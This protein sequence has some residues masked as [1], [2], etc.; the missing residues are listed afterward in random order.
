MATSPMP[1]NWVYQVC[2]Q[3]T[4]FKLGCMTSR[5]KSLVIEHPGEPGL[6]DPRGSPKVYIIYRLG[7]IIGR[8]LAFPP[9]KTA[10]THRADL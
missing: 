10:N 1:K 3:H 7:D 4:W 2:D 5:P 9:I 8:W 6:E